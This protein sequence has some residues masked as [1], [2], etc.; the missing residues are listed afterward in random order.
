M[1]LYLRNALFILLTTV[2]ILLSNMAIAGED[3]VSNFPSFSEEI[4]MLERSGDSGSEFLPAKQAF[5]PSLWIEGN[6]LFIGFNIEDEYYLYRDRIR[7]FSRDDDFKIND[8]SLTKGQEITD[9][10]FGDVFIYE[11]KAIVSAEIETER[12]NFNSIPVTLTFQGCAKA[13]LCY[14]I[15]NVLAEVKQF[16]P[17]SSF[18]DAYQS[19]IYSDSLIVA[20]NKDD[21]DAVEE[22][23]SSNE[24][25]GESGVTDL[26]SSFDRS[27]FS[28][29]IIFFL[30]GVGLS[31]TP[32]V[33]PMLPILSS[34]I[35][36][37]D[38]DRKQ[39]FK[40][41]ASYSIGVIF[42]YTLFGVIMGLVGAGLNI[43]AYLQSPYVVI[44]IASIFTLFAL[45]MFSIINPSSILKGSGRI[46]S[47]IT[48]LQSNLS[49]AG[50]L[51]SM[52]AGMLS[53]LVLSPCVS[54]PLAGVL[55]YISTTGDVLTGAITLLA[56]SMGMSLLLI[57][58]G[59]FGVSSIPK[60]GAWMQNVKNIFGFMLLGMS[61]WVVGYLIDPILYQLL[62]LIVIVLI[63][64]QVWGVSNYM[65]KDG[66]LNYILKSLVILIMVGLVS[67]TMTTISG[68]QLNKNSY[69]G[70]MQS[71]Y[72]DIESL[73]EV[74]EYTEDGKY[75]V[76]F[77]AD[78]CVSCRQ[79]ERS[80]FGSNELRNLYHDNEI[81]VLKVDVTRNNERNREI[82]T[83]YNLFGPPSFLLIADGEL[84]DVVQGE[85]NLE[86]GINFS[87]QL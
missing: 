13:G 40:L 15:E 45:I 61:A 86:Q 1:G 59:T 79:I 4:S 18:I 82:L 5:A 44:P 10:F 68:H 32:C 8:I 74:K 6:T 36:G 81:S 76:Y 60:A 63:M 39:A 62:L 23:I 70:S 35:V 56:M 80:V 52:I 30:I 69:Q 2:S 75:V 46:G 71:F 24:A 83:E 48:D 34:I 67:Y 42:V 57:V 53:V 29:F 11:G 12:D 49:K 41:S 78:W 14:P 50:T 73:D 47:K 87:Q 85:I 38:S 25:N 77:S 84:I 20:D 27:F 37:R 31:F 72:T 55:V 9:E 33:L 43:Q 28:L 7:V 21:L 51:G 19:F 26:T 65:S 64:V 22:G 17:P 3:K 16:Y 54:A 58:A 66:I